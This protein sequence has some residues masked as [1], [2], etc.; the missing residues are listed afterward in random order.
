V[1]AQGP[2]GEG[3]KALIVVDV[4]IRPP[5]AA[6]ADFAA[7]LRERGYDPACILGGG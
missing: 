7:K 6:G 2:H 4:P 5:I 1:L 3:A